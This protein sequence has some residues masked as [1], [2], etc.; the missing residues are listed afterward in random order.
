MDIDLR[1][2]RFVD[3]TNDNLICCICQ[4]P[5]IEPV[6]STCGHT[7]CQHCIFQALESSPLCPIDRKPLS[8]EDFVPAAKIISNMVNELLVYCPRQEQGCPHIGQR[9]YIESHLKHDCLYIMAPCE[10]EEC[11]ELLLRKDLPRH[12]ETCK[13][14][15]LQCN[16]CKKSMCAYELEDHYERCPSETITCQHCNTSR[17]RSEHSSHVNDCPQF[18]VVCDHHEFG[19]SWSN[20]R[21]F[22]TDHISQCPYEGIK[23]FL[24]KQKHT[25]ASLRNEIHQL[26]TENESL[27][28]SH[29]DMGKRIESLTQQLDL[30]FP[31]HFV[32]N[33]D[34]PENAVLS[35][36]QRMSNE[37]ESLSASIA[38]LE[39]K[40]NMALMTETFRLQEELQSLRAICHGLR[41]QM[42]YL[43]MERKTSITSNTNAATGANN[44]GN[45]DTS[46]AN[47]LGRMRAWLEPVTSPRQE[48][49]L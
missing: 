9:Q 43:M 40:Q 1:T 31:G 45:G 38:S 15:I 13:Y 44:G 18:V 4:T 12:A 49:K 24:H 6:I 8:T 11:K 20:E 41:M 19:C 32:P 3:S 30:M 14:R 48:T 37:L 47:T 42:H 22:L 34:T 29:Y 5:F 46:A 23:S 28:R 17:P 39:L 26:H 35:E 33:S 10:L 21:Q 7:F 27:K 2:V 36:N 16:M 25:E